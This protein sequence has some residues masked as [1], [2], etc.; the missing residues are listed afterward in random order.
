MDWWMI[1]A[2]ANA[3]VGVAYLGIFLA[4]LRPLVASG[5]LRSN[6]LGLAT[7]GIFLTCAVHHGSHTVHLLGPSLGFEVHE[8][9]A[10]REAFGWH[11]A[12][13]DLLTA[14]VGVYYWTLRRAYGALFKGAQ[15][16]EDMKEKQRQALEIN[17]NIVQGLTVAHMALS[18]DERK[19]SQ[20]AI[21]QT[22]VAARKVISDLLG[23]A[24][25]GEA[26][27]AAGDLVRRGPAIPTTR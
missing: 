6:R 3:V 5:Q 12:A 1:A 14:G 27:L 23:E 21:E 19:Q 18:L 22:L 8:G 7:A 13:W 17:D 20:E 11:V 10:L 9:L 2:I 26:Q 25:E 24:K 16:F 15:L 4:I